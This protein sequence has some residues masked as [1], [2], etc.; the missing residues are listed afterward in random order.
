MIQVTAQ[1]FADFGEMQ[2]AAEAAR[3]PAFTSLHR[4]SDGNDYRL[5]TFGGGEQSTQGSLRGGASLQSIVAEKPLAR[6]YGME[7][8]PPS[9]S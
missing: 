7:R 2:A 8:G 1:R 3:V 6:A 4:L 9:A 5:L